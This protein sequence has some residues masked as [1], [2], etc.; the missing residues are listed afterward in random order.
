MKPYA[1]INMLRCFLRFAAK[2]VSFSEAVFA[3]LGGEG[4]EADLWEELGV[5]PDRGWL[6]ERQ[7]LRSVRLIQNLPYRVCTNLSILPRVLGAVFSKPSID[8]FHLDLCG[9]LRPS[10]ENFRPVLKLIARSRGRC[11]AITVADQRRNTDQENFHETWECATKL[12]GAKS[13]AVLYERIC[14]EQEMIGTAKGAQRELGVV[15]HVAKLLQSLPR[16]PMPDC[17]ERY[18][19]VS[20]MQ[21]ASFRMRTYCFHFGDAIVN[22]KDR[23]VALPSFWTSKPLRNYNDGAFLSV[24]IPKTREGVTVVGKKSYPRLVAIVKAVGGEA[25]QELEQLLALVA[26]GSK[27]DAVRN[28][29]QELNQFLQTGSASTSESAGHQVVAEEGVAEAAVPLNVK[30]QLLMLRAKREGEDMEGAYLQVGKLLG[31]T[32]RKGWRHTV[33]ALFAR[34]QGKFRAN[35]VRR[36]VAACGVEVLDELAFIYTTISGEIVTV[37]QLKREARD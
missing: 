9:T 36:V 32:R 23:P 31:I 10:V 24:G 22:K 17:I 13:L 12:F 28:T 26:E 7:K 6:I 1:K 29:V 2:Y 20:D 15:V 16:M 8:V 4:Y 14:W 3:T 27:L 19:Y 33:G 11:F 37:A 30:C 18:L 21:G 35:F 34:T 5:H 25:E